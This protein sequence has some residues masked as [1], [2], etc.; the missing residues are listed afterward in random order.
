MTDRP[1]PAHLDAGDLCAGDSALQIACDRL[2]LGELWHAVS[3]ADPPVLD[4]DCGERLQ[5]L[6]RFL[7]GDLGSGL[8]QA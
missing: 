7:G 4:R 1:I 5:R 6:V 8:L 2:D 3:V